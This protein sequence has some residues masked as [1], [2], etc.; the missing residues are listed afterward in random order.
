MLAVR[1]HC[2][3]PIAT[4][5]LRSLQCL[6]LQACRCEH[7]HGHHTHRQQ[8]FQK[9]H[10]PLS[11][12]HPC[13]SCDFSCNCIE[14]GRLDRRSNDREATAKHFQ[15]GMHGEATRCNT[16]TNVV[17]P[18]GGRIADTARHA[19]LR[20]IERRPTQGGSCARP[21]AGAAQCAQPCHVAKPAGAGAGVGR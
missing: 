13:T 21:G 18:G 10:A 3:L 5:V 15:G 1:R 19:G 16:D 6:Q 11:C 4:R 20:Q 17:G 2:R 9:R 8:H 14:P 7:T 12:V